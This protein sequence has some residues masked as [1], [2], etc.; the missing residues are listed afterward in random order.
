MKYY[1]VDPDEFLD[2]VHNIDFSKLKN[3]EL[4]QYLKL[5]PGKRLFLL[6]VMR[7]TPQKFFVLWGLLI[8]L[9]KY[10]ILKKEIIYQSQR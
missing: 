6:M 7:I 2:Y 9:M 4:N 1:D 5:L 8:I 10:M 3:D